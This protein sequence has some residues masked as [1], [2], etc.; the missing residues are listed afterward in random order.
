MA[1]YIF[2]I[3]SVLFLSGCSIVDQ[4]THDKYNNQD[5]S[6]I[7]IDTSEI[8]ESE[9]EGRVNIHIL[10]N[11]QPVEDAD[12]TLYSRPAKEAEVWN[13]EYEVTKMD[14]HYTADVEIPR[15]GL[16]LLTLHVKTDHLDASPIKFFTVG[17]L[18]MFEEVF[19]QEYQNDDSAGGHS[20]H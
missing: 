11:G 4:S 6:D 16:Y 7:V 17:E 3:F 10:E 9:T 2:L 19:L 18:D 8:T 1:K 20:H 13:E 5:N 14:D 12:I 15:D